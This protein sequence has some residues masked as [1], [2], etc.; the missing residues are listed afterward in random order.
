MRIVEDFEERLE[1]IRKQLNLERVKS[2]I[3][4]LEREST[5]PGFWDDPEAAGKKMQKLS[6]LQSEISQVESL[7]DE[8]E[9]LAMMQQ[10]EG[11]GLEDQAKKIEKELKALETRLFLSGKY[12]RR[13]AI[14]S[15][16]AGQGGTEAQDWVSMLARMYEQFCK[17]RSW[18]IRKIEES[19]GTEAGY[20]SIAYQIKGSFAYGYLKHEVG[21]HRLVRQSPFNADNLRQT[22]FAL[23]EVVPVLESDNE[24]ELKESELELKTARSGGA[25]GQNVNKVETAVQLTHIPTGITV[26][27]SAERSQFKNRQIAMNLLRGKLARRKEEERE[28]Q[29]AKLKGEYKKPAWGNQIRS[30]VLHPYQM[31][32]DH[33]TQTEVT[34]ADSVLDGNLTPFIDAELRLL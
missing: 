21:T 31:V 15:I 7:A 29:E 34:D 3:V 32:K 9:L 23:V 24:I 27:V 1:T 13:D 4:Q 18:Q 28:Q 5:Q 19:P 30:Y 22:S 11:A 10:E 8:I 17:S 12:D 25:G 26:Q 20:K 6:S 33:R 16:H 14:L 2:Q